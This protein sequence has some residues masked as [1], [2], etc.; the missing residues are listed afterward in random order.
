MIRLL[1]LW[2]G[3]IDEIKD[4][5]NGIGILAQIERSSSYF[6]VNYDVR[7]IIVGGNV[8]D[9]DESLHDMFMNRGNTQYLFLPHVG[10]TT[11]LI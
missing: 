7:S 2:M 4:V 5:E 3:Y 10:H 9:A 11:L 8:G 6:D 1:W